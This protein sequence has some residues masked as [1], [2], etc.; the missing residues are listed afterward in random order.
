MNYTLKT[1]K[2]LFPYYKE[3]NERPTGYDLYIQYQVELGNVESVL[4]EGY[5]CISG[6]DYYK[7][8]EKQDELFTLSHNDFNVKI[9][10]YGSR[11]F[12]TFWVKSKKA[13]AYIEDGYMS[14]YG[15]PD[16]E[17][18]ANIFFMMEELDI[19]RIIFVSRKPITHLSSAIKEIKDVREYYLLFGKF[20]E[21]KVDNVYQIY[22]PKGKY[23]CNGPFQR[24]KICKNWFRYT[25]EELAFFRQ[26]NINGTATCKRC[27][28]RKVVN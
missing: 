5:R 10:W 7:L 27:K 26:N 12:Q 8:L 2:D 13:V 6:P 28:G 22:N 18:V 9:D 21:G 23:F 11:E 24:C 19:K 17:L 16:R 1:T 15:E 4:E 3:G 14:I 25:T 20:T